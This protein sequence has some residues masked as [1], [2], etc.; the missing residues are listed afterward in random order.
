MRR[1]RIEV[2]IRLFDVL[3]VIALG[4]AQAK[5]ALLQNR[6]TPVPQ[7]ERKTEATLAIANSEQAVFAPAISAAAGV[8]MRKIIPARAAGRIILAHRAPLPLDQIR[9][10]PLPVSHPAARAGIIFRM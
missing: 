10:P 2:E 6:V 5:K 7:G 8:V 3:A 1:R 4:S 9:S